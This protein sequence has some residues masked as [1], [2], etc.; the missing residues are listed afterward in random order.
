MTHAGPSRSRRALVLAASLAFALGCG[1]SRDEIETVI[2]RG[3]PLIQAIQ[4]YESLNGHPPASLHVLV[5][6]YIREIPTTG[7]ESFP[8]F[9]YD[10][11]AGSAPWL[12][13]VRVRSLGFKHMRFDPSGRHP[14]PVTPLRDGWVMMD[15]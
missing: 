5:P 4:A 7:L 8:K 10:A 3:A 11:P 13:S 12:L 2:D 6:K 15:P 14:V 9:D 1:V